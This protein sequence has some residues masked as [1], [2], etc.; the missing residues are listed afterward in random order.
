MGLSLRLAPRKIAIVL[1]V[2]AVLL[3]LQSL[4]AEYLLANILD[5]DFDLAPAPLLDALSV[6]IE[7]SIPTWFSTINLFLAACLLAWV[8]MIKHAGREPYRAHWAGLALIFFYLSADEG[9][10]I[11]ETAS[12]PLQDAFE[13]SSFFEFGWLLIGIPV[14]IV[15]ALAYLRFWWRLPE[16]TRRRFAL[17]AALYI[18]GAVIVEAISAN[19]YSLDD[20]ASFR[21]LAV[22][23][24]E[25]LCEML[26]VIVLIYA[27]LDYL[28]ERDAR[29]AFLTQTPVA[30]FAPFRA[31]WPFSLRATAIAL[32]AILLV[33]NVSLLAWSFSQE[34]EVE[35]AVADAAPYHFYIAV[36]ELA[37]DGVTIAHFSGMLDPAN[38]DA[39]QTV[40]ALSTGF[41]SVQVLSLPAL[42]ASVAVASETPVLTDEDVIALMEWIGEPEYIFYDTDIVRAVL[43][44][45]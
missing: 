23:T 6:N 42:N 1:S 36:E 4:F 39:R 8:A 12:N 35:T 18:G 37:G 25:E 38:D 9:A 33:A 7:E 41:A 21:Y 16:P 5:F 26:G 2:I 32:A 30:E 15:F 14:V 11:H 22:A 10:A 31:R 20:G 17:A 3:A 44:I 45:P 19:F 13:T 43:A 24:V 28:S 34:P 29:L 27:L 40:S